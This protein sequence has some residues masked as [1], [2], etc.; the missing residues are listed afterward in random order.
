MYLNNKTMNTSIRG[1]NEYREKTT[2]KERMEKE[3]QDQQPHWWLY[4]G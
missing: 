2:Y 1:M 3:L 4:K